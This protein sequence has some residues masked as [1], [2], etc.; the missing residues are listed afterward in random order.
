MEKQAQ[1]A[2][3]LF[4]D[5]L[6]LAANHQLFPLES[7]A[8]KMGRRLLGRHLQI[9]AH[10]HCRITSF[11]GEMTF[12]RHHI[13]ESIGLDRWTPVH[14]RPVD[15]SVDQ[16]VITVMLKLHLHD[17]KSLNYCRSRYHVE[18]QTSSGDTF[19]ERAF[20]SALASDQDNR[21]AKGE[22]Y[23]LPNAWATRHSVLIRRPFPFNKLPAEVRLQIWDWALIK[24]VSHEMVDR[25]YRA[26][27]KAHAEDCSHRMRC[28]VPLQEASTGRQSLLV[29]WTIKI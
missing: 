19:T 18:I 24:D 28:N 25:S 8:V 23:E 15:C 7:D 20:F 22:I 29:R 14:I 1:H 3:R 16:F 2:I 13:T 5:C 9:W 11:Q 26:T 12:C 21:R 17:F 10:E 6:H 27:V 4:C